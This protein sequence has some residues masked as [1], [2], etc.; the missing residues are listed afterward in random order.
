ME[1]RNDLVPGGPQESED[2]Q[3]SNLLPP[4]VIPHEEYGIRYQFPTPGYE[5]RENPLEQGTPIF[6]QFTGAFQ[7]VLRMFGLDAGP[8]ELTES[9]DPDNPL[10][11][12][13]DITN[14]GVGIP[15]EEIDELLGPQSGAAKRIRDWRRLLS[16]AGTE[17]LIVPGIRTLL[18]EENVSFTLEGRYASG[19]LAEPQDLEEKLIDRL[20]APLAGG[21][22][23]GLA[24]YQVA[25]VPAMA[26]LKTPWARKGLFRLMTGKKGPAIAKAL[27][28]GGDDVTRALAR[29]NKA[30]QTS[31]ELVADVASGAGYGAA[32]GAR[33]GLETQGEVDWGDAF[34]WG[35][36]GAGAGLLISGPL[37]AARFKYSTRNINRAMEAG[38]IKHAG[39][40]QYIK[41]NLPVG[42]ELPGAGAWWDGS[43]WRK[44]NPD[45]SHSGD[46]ASR[47]IPE[48]FDDMTPEQAVH[49]GEALM[50]SQM[51]SLN[52]TTRA[53]LGTKKNFED[54]WREGK[55]STVLKRLEE[56]GYKV[57]ELLAATRSQT[58]DLAGA[59][60]PL[61]GDETAIKAVV[62]F[63]AN[64]SQVD[65]AS[66]DLATA[67][68]QAA[69][70]LQ[71]K[72]DIWNRQELA[73]EINARDGV[74]RDPTQDVGLRIE[75]MA[76]SNYLKELARQHGMTPGDLKSL[77]V[78]LPTSSVPIEAA[79]IES[80]ATELAQLKSPEEFEARLQHYKDMATNAND[81]SFR[82]R[83]NRI[84]DRAFQKRKA[85]GLQDRTPYN[86]ALK[87][88]LS[89]I[90]V[91][92]DR[93]L[94]TGAQVFVR[95]AD[96]TLSKGTIDSIPRLGKAD[97]KVPG[98]ARPRKG[99]D[100][101][102][103][104]IF[105][106]RNDWVLVDYNGRTVPGKVRDISKAGPDTG[107][108]V[109]IADP[110]AQGAS[111]LKNVDVGN[112]DVLFLAAEG[113][114]IDR[115]ALPRVR[116]AREIVQQRFRRI[117][118]EEAPEGIEWDPAFAQRNP[119]DRMVTFRG[120]QWEAVE[121]STDGQF[122]RLKHRKT[123]IEMDIGRKNL[124][125]GYEGLVNP[126]LDLS[127]GA[128]RVEK[129]AEARTPRGKEV[130]PEEVRVD[131]ETNA[132][133]PEAPVA[134]AA[135][136]GINIS[137]YETGLGKDLSNLT[138]L[139]VEYGGRIYRSAEEAYQANKKNLPDLGD[140]NVLNLM[141][142]IIENKLIR[143][144]KLVGRIHAA[145]GMDLLE[146]SSHNLIKAGKTV[147]KD[148]WTGREGLFMQALRKAYG[149]RTGELP[150]P[151]APKG[152][153]H[154]GG[155]KG[156]DTVWQDEALAAGYDVQAHTFEGAHKLNPKRVEHTAEELAQADE[157]AKR[158]NR[159]LGRTWPPRS[160]FVANLIRRNFFQ[161]KDS[162]QVV[163]IGRI[164]EKP[165]FPRG[166]LEVEG[167]TGWA[168][169]FGIDMD[170]PVYIFDQ[171]RKKW[172]TWDKGE[173]NF[174]ESAMPEPSPAFAG[175]G[176]RDL[177]PSGRKAIK[178]FFGSEEPAAPT[179]K[180]LGIYNT[181][182]PDQLPAKGHHILYVKVPREYAK[183][184]QQGWINGDPVEVLEGLKG[185][186]KRLTGKKFRASPSPPPAGTVG[187]NVVLAIEVPSSVNPK[188]T[189]GF[190][191]TLSFFETGNIDDP[192]DLAR[193]SATFSLD[194]IEKMRGLYR[195]PPDHSMLDFPQFTKL[196][197]AD[198]QVKQDALT[199]ARMRIG[200]SM[201]LLGPE[202]V[203]VVGKLNQL[204]RA[205]QRAATDPPVAHAE[206]G[207]KRWVK[208]EFEAMEEAASTARAQRPTF[209]DR[210]ERLQL[211]SREWMNGTLL[212]YMSWNPRGKDAR[213]NPVEPAIDRVFGRDAV[214]DDALHLVRQTFDRIDSEIGDPPAR[215]PDEPYPKYM[216]RR[217]EWEAGVDE[218]Y[219]RNFDE[220]ADGLD[221]FLTQNGVSA[222]GEDPIRMRFNHGTTPGRSLDIY[223][224][225]P[226]VVENPVRR[227]R[228]AAQEA[229]ELEK[230]SG[231]IPDLGKAEKGRNPP[232]SEGTQQRIAE[233]AQSV[234]ART[235]PI[236]RL[237]LGPQE[238]RV[239]TVGGKEMRV[240]YLGEVGATDELVQA[241]GYGAQGP[242][243]KPQQ[244]WV[245]GQKR[246]HVYQFEDALPP[247]P[248][249]ESSPARQIVVKEVWPQ[250]RQGDPVNLAAPPVIPREAVELLV[251]SSQIPRLERET[252]EAVAAGQKPPIQIY[253]EQILRGETPN[254]QGHNPYWRPSK[255][256]ELEGL[257][258][259]SLARESGE[260]VL[261]ETLINEQPFQDD[262]FL[263]AL[264]R[265]EES[266][267]PFDSA[268]KA[269][270]ARDALNQFQNEIDRVSI[271]RR[272][273]PP[274]TGPGRP[275]GEVL[276]V[277]DESADFL[278]GGRGLG[279]GMSLPSHLQDLPEAST[280]PDFFGQVMEEFTRR[281]GRRPLRREG[282]ALADYSVRAKHWQRQADQFLAEARDK[283]ERAL[284]GEATD[285]E[286]YSPF[287]AREFTDLE[288]RLLQ[289]DPELVAIA[290]GVA[291][292]RGTQVTEELIDELR[293][294]QY[295]RLLRLAG[296]K[297]DESGK[298]IDLG[299]GARSPEY[300]R[301]IEGIDRS[302]T[303]VDFAIPAPQKSYR[304]QL[305]DL[306][307]ILHHYDLGTGQNPGIG[308]WV[309]PL[310]P[311][312]HGWVR[313]VADGQFMVY[314]GD[315][316]DPRGID[317]RSRPVRRKIVPDYEAAERALEEAGFRRNGNPAVFGSSKYLSKMPALSRQVI[318]DETNRTIT[319]AA[320]SP[321]ETIELN[322]E[323]G[324]AIR[325][326]RD[327]LGYVPQPLVDYANEFI[328]NGWVRYF[329]A[330]EPALLFDDP[331][332]FESIGR[333]R[334]PRGEA[335]ILNLHPE[336]SSRYEWVEDELVQKY[337]DQDVWEQLTKQPGYR[338]IQNMPES[339]RL[340][341]WQK[342]GLDWY[343]Q[344]RFLTYAYMDM[345]QG[346][347]PERMISGQTRD[348]GFD[349]F[350]PMDWVAQPRVLFKD[351]D[352]TRAGFIKRANVGPGRDEM[353]IR[354]WSDKGWVE[355]TVSKS[356]VSKTLEPRHDWLEMD[357]P[358]FHPFRKTSAMGE[359]VVD[360]KLGVGGI[361][362]P[363]QYVEGLAAAGRN[364][365]V[366]D[367]QGKKV[368][369]FV[370]VNEEGK[371]VLSFTKAG[372]DDITDLADWYLRT[373]ETGKKPSIQRQLKFLQE[374]LE[375][376]VRIRN[377]S[378][379]EE[380][381]QMKAYERAKQIMQ[382]DPEDE[383]AHHVA[384]NKVG[385][386]DPVVEK[387]FRKL[388][389]DTFLETKA[390]K[391]AADDLPL[392][393]ILERM[394]NQGIDRRL[395]ADVRANIIKPGIFHMLADQHGLLDLNGELR[396]L[397]GPANGDLRRLGQWYNFPRY[398]A[399]KHPAFRMLYRMIG[400]AWR[401]RSVEGKRLRDIVGQYW[402]SFDPDG[403]NLAKIREIRKKYG[404]WDGFRTLGGDE[405][406]EWSKK[407]LRYEA[408]DGTERIMSFKEYF[409]EVHIELEKA[410][411]EQIRRHLEM[412]DELITITAGESVP[413][414]G[415][416]NIEDPRAEAIIADYQG[417]FN[418]A[419]IKK[420]LENG[421]I[422]RLISTF[423]EGSMFR[424]RDD[425]SVEFFVQN[426]LR[427]R[428]AQTLADIDDDIITMIA[429]R[430][431]KDADGNPT[432]PWG[433]MID[434]ADF[435]L[436]YGRDDYW[437]L[438][439]E[440]RLKLMKVMPN[441]KEQVF[442][443]VKTEAQARKWLDRLK[444]QGDPDIQEVLDVGDPNAGYFYVK[445][446]KTRIDAEQLQLAS[447]EISRRILEGLEQGGMPIEEGMRYL[448]AIQVSS[449]PTG[450]RNVSM[451]PR[452]EGGPRSLTDNPFDEL[453]IY[454]N[455]VY[456][457]RYTNR[458]LRA[459]EMTRQA[460]QGLSEAFGVKPLFGH[461]T[462]GASIK[463]A[464]YQGMTPELTRMHQFTQDYVRAMIGERTVLEQKIDNALRHWYWFEQLG[465][466][467]SRKFG[468]MVRQG[469]RGEEDPLVNI[470]DVIQETIGSSDDDIY[471]RAFRG[472]EI[473][474][475][476]LQTQAMFR[477]GVSP[478]AAGVNGLQWMV[479]SMP[480]L[481][482]E[483]AVAA[484][485]DVR[486]IRANKK[487]F[488][489]L[490]ELHGPDWFQ[491]LL[492]GDP[493]VKTSLPADIIE[494]KKFMDDVGVS[495]YIARSNVEEPFGKALTEIG[496]L[497]S[498][499]LRNKSREVYDEIADASL[500]W[501]N[502]AEEINRMVTALGALRKGKADGITD[503][504]ELVSY[505]RNLIDNT[506][507]EY[508]E[509]GLPKFM[510]ASHAKVLTQFKPFM[511]N[512]LKYEKELLG[513][514][515]RREPK[516]LRQFMLHYGTL[517]TF[518]GLSGIA[519]SPVLYGILTAAAWAGQQGR[520]ANGT[521]ETGPEGLVANLLYRVP[522]FGGRA[523]A[524]E[525][526]GRFDSPWFNAKN[527]VMYGLPGVFGIDFSRRLN[528]SGPEVMASSLHDFGQLVAGPHVG[529]YWDLVKAMMDNDEMPAH[530]GGVGRYGG[531]A[532][533]VL[534]AP[535]LKGW[536]GVIGAVGLNQALGGKHE[537]F[538]DPKGIGRGAAELV[539]F[540]FDNRDITPGALFSTK[541]GRK[542]V[543]NL[544]PTF[545][546]NIQAAAT[547]LNYGYQFDIGLN[548]DDIGNV[549]WNKH[550]NLPFYG[551]TTLAAINEAV[552]KAAGFAP[553]RKRFDQMLEQ[554]R[555]DETRAYERKANMW[556]QRIAEAIVFNHDVAG[557]MAQAE[558]DGVNL[559]ED[560][561]RERIERLTTDYIELGAGRVPTDLRRPPSEFGA[562]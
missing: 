472:R 505:A 335:D 367:F 469:L 299:P 532:V 397:K 353:I 36:F 552:M 425:H 160:D 383:L 103:V 496:S 289:E 186:D 105:P 224:T 514:V 86:E 64:P 360:E 358:D 184:A 273:P 181:M 394:G 466:K 267:D 352:I 275:E 152:V 125:D 315:A 463:Q 340:H 320:L 445:A 238:S 124:A 455:R 255:A 93:G 266:I 102:E 7:S 192:M 172:F 45:G 169:Q 67:M 62:G 204:N 138:N 90:S 75:A 136:K 556:A 89:D 129:G 151:A 96:G 118:G 249:V 399:E 280:D 127:E 504:R 168:V 54:F 400:Q 24:A 197:L 29:L 341:A 211:K 112:R 132:A 430:A 344:D 395:I 389:K 393:E 60:P 167:G 369:P 128:V 53:V 520:T 324:T 100:L 414:R 120:Q 421:E 433:W 14:P 81:P 237:K 208:N 473:A 437:P 502:S 188:R 560:N 70:K 285:L 487:E 83:A 491:K 334:E 210:I 506:Q 321:G 365:L 214:W 398:V 408:Y 114:D 503:Y 217:R 339:Q 180:A 467:L 308:E 213:V 246:L 25:K 510:R 49:M 149:R 72:F 541:K 203:E 31:G 65:A 9:T 183:R 17:S 337:T 46:F 50:S 292:A 3:Q 373:A 376:P 557:I 500:Y 194:Q 516:A 140:E 390:E 428:H 215:L 538:V 372:E 57:D 92:R 247:I 61:T 84:I 407:N 494:M 98:E 300:T 221:Q 345:L 218:I 27:S 362:D 522:I 380:T 42:Y 107:L 313:E 488:Q 562:P 290:S 226:G 274:G 349:I 311:S 441:Q 240:T 144:P 21:L 216:T 190:S 80:T 235:R 314:L 78:E 301:L 4:L 134:P 423:K 104:V 137:S 515:I 251:K 391:E 199:L 559:D 312:L 272:K 432:N 436:N 537:P 8:T 33:V 303:G 38:R 270:I 52:A 554:V 229:L 396:F 284:R 489:K 529:I 323:L 2:E 493:N 309:H 154:S 26:L 200:N 193:A 281:V 40:V 123:G 431:T 115:G 87:I 262:P 130:K 499:A 195:V 212:Q 41:D 555:R 392:W 382:A 264:A 153:V 548:R 173:R 47:P 231:R 377:A 189:K 381:I 495:L 244:E 133:V 234:S 545:L 310:H 227:M 268:A 453:M 97:V 131:P 413:E 448:G 293:G 94:Y 116:K 166:Q 348:I 77:G 482:P 405:Y 462:E 322:R 254:I 71:E 44:L 371:H 142:D 343:D 11:M 361:T 257:Y 363:D 501:F 327:D 449:S 533:T 543:N 387:D 276:D 295:E 551:T 306:A 286:D 10:Q 481:G 497:E 146:G 109:L 287:Q 171:L 179:S 99:V 88:R 364:L 191:E 119:A 256:K 519:Y 359:S 316:P 187:D 438:I 18:G 37:Q 374:E 333:T 1:A 55:I 176:S 141:T 338:T 388:F 206:R 406:A 476:I 457:N 512:Q 269:E 426:I 424:M 553:A 23:P 304:D 232:I 539:G 461:A 101:A 174:V 139:D 252:L 357:L 459:L 471:Y 509:L 422:V 236:G 253:Y 511:L 525:G 331:A 368:S 150:T 528:V 147:K 550:V 386:T 48:V 517:A 439:H 346:T 122:F 32:Y 547:I 464:Q 85:A 243:K 356:D 325:Q 486:L 347:S 12:V 22:V 527:V 385:L 126:T 419:E 91:E 404:D 378:E 228:R 157:W 79:G 283:I 475:D 401:Q 540:E 440:G 82:E 498:P 73:A 429:S 297:L 219:E 294:V 259:W 106:T 411:I 470:K 523:Q 161:V 530:V 278:Y 513:R 298:V 460:D 442:A 205:A 250:G 28:E 558:R 317:W 452:R 508:S 175:V 230:Q 451:L 336:R 483:H 526:H 265:S 56:A 282:E 479:N 209:G 379:F 260:A 108:K 43:K 544:T 121:K 13:F 296:K 536:G 51:A 366:K 74:W 412:G 182:Q 465:P 177:K 202:H 159:T 271:R 277:V 263:R 318:D 375:I 242:R 305:L 549:A 68:D 145:G 531:L 156:A 245:A 220:V 350:G 239:A 518:G 158:A 434:E 409:D 474:R 415:I 468:R 417:F 20:L 546:R 58:E 370:I 354:T 110:A 342:A 155:A 477:L 561:F 403:T 490:L 291:D 163:A 521:Y 258:N 39:H 435:W 162:D 95:N 480:I 484:A 16:A 330:D 69:P 6:R 223:V 456:N 261:P 225:E 241:A 30:A 113:G 427:N 288:Q 458:V 222:V 15:D 492:A 351:G 201:G 63:D 302:Y 19:T 534:G 66:I 418:P 185:G 196:D 164:K 279:E 416:Y 402:K 328:D 117:L 165:G 170:K 307:K 443:Y 329:D 478:A 59:I 198:P 207:T 384:E 454:F 148:R 524:R 326:F 485:R 143:H 233:G 507:F 76:E 35:A 332:I 444:Q 135:V 355:K 178:Q 248:E 34:R 410:R 319:R 111:K 5:L 446:D 542:F 447:P 535:L 450:R 420:Q